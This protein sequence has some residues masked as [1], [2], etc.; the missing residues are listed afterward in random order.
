MAGY[1]DVSALISTP[2]CL[3]ACL[4]ASAGRGPVVEGGGG[5]GGAVIYVA[6]E[7]GAGMAVVRG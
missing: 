6:R 3:L 1:S 5:G 2:A 7:V 4:L